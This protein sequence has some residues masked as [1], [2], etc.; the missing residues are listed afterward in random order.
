MELTRTAGS[1]PEAGTDAL[2][3][4]PAAEVLAMVEEKAT[5]P[6]DTHRLPTATGLDHAEADG[7]DALLKHIALALADDRDPAS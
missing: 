7:T 1:L 6:P 3:K 2:R 4:H 5:S